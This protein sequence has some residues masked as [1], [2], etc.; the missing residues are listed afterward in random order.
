MIYYYGKLLTGMGNTVPGSKWVLQSD[1]LH[2]IGD[3]VMSYD[4]IMGL[5][6][7][8]ITNLLPKDHPSTTSVRAYSCIYDCFALQEVMNVCESNS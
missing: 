3:L 5:M 8:E 2:K 7:H 1:R 4:H 6:I